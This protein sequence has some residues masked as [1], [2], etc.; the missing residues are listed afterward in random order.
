[1][2]FP[3]Q[4]QQQDSNKNKMNKTNGAGGMM[5]NLIN[6]NCTRNMRNMTYDDNSRN[7]ITNMD[8]FYLQQQNSYNNG[9]INNSVF[10]GRLAKNSEEYYQTQNVAAH[11]TNK[12]LNSEQK[13]WRDAIRKALYQISFWFT[14]TNGLLTQYMISNASNF[15]VIK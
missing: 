12:T 6:R 4:S 5:G 7:N 1:M 10:S 3:F 11:F 2:F 9:T 13:Y 8:S 15:K 14:N